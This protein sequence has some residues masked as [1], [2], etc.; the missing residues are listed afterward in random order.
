MV[1][2]WKYFHPF[3]Y[4]CVCKLTHTSDVCECMCVCVCVCV[5]SLHFIINMCAHIDAHTNTHRG[6]NDAIICLSPRYVLRRILRR[7]VRYC[8]EKLNGKPGTFANLVPTVVE[9]LVSIKF[10]VIIV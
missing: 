2:T 7:G 3:V 6:S 10:R 8:T 4:T 1:P 5:K 9:I